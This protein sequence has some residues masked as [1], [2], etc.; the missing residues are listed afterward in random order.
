MLATGKVCLGTNVL[1]CKALNTC[2]DILAELDY[3]HSGLLAMEENVN[4]PNSA[5]DKEASRK[6][7]AGEANEQEYNNFFYLAQLFLRRQLN[8][9]HKKIYSVDRK[10]M[11]IAGIGVWLTS[12]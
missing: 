1:C 12:L 4:W 7:V 5:L 11:Y 10:F 8:A 3:P 9:I 6:L 2:S